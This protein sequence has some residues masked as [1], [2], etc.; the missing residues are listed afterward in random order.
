MG[1]R[2]IPAV[3]V[4]G[5]KYSSVGLLGLPL[6]LEYDETTGGF[7]LV[8][9][10]ENTLEVT[11]TG[12]SVTVGSVSISGPVVQANNVLGAQYAE[13]S[14]HVS[15]ETG[16][17]VL[18]VRQDSPLALAGAGD[19]T[20]F[21]TDALGRLHTFT[22][23]SFVTLSS[24]LQIGAVEI[25]DS[26]TDD[27]V[28]VTADG[29]LWT[30]TLITGSVDTEL[31]AAST[32]ADFIANPLSPAVQ[33]FPY[34]Y[35]QSND[36]WIRARTV[37]DADALVV[38]SITGSF[39]ST[40]FN[41]FWSNDTLGWHRA[42][43]DLQDRLM[44][45]AVVSGTITTLAGSL[46]AL[47]QRADVA[48]AS[49]VRTLNSDV[50]APGV[51]GVS[52]A[53]H[54][55]SFDQ[56]DDLWKRNRSI[57]NVDTR[58]ASELMPTLAV[59]ALLQAFRDDVTNGVY[60]RI[61]GDLQNRLHT[62]AFVT[63]T[64]VVDSAS[65]LALNQRADVAIASPVVSLF[66]D[67]LVSPPT[68]IAA[69]SFLLGYDGSSWDRVGVV[70]VETPN[71]VSI[72]G[73]FINALITAGMNLGFDSSFTGEWKSIGAR[74]P[75]DAMP[76]TQNDIGFSLQS[77][78]YLVGFSVLGSSWNRLRTIGTD[79]DNIAINAT[80]GT[81]QAGAFLYGF[82][83]FAWDRVGI[84]TTR[85]LMTSALVT[86]S[87]TVLPGSSL[88]LNQP[89]DVRIV[90]PVGAGG[91]N[92]DPTATGVIAQSR[93]YGYDSGAGQWGRVERGISGSIG[94]DLFS[95][96]ERTQDE[97]TAYVTGTFP[98]QVTMVSGSLPWKNIIRASITISGTAVGEATVVSAVPGQRIHILELML[99]TDAATQI[100]WKDGSGGSFL[101]G[102][103]ALPNAGDG[104]FLQSPENPDH[105]HFRTS[106]NTALILLR[107]ANTLL[108]GHIHYFL[109]P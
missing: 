68:G 50:L 33:T 27:R 83:G 15:G 43:R 62:R 59:G 30:S 78:S 80:E 5:E 20:P 57:S 69:A 60:E 71:P 29:R 74:F 92:I 94:V 52:T 55:M 51:T 99:L 28:R 79:R 66:S 6:V 87:V 14:L 64:V 84:D 37:R 21:Q 70:S 3:P 24:D 31:P 41:R 44:V 54:G 48:I 9:D 18:A 45:A 107:T 108:G 61:H 13:D 81:L 10:V 75:T 42:L 19:Y 63:G 46:T 34:L 56:A 102:P 97:V 36:L 67:N 38:R 104:Y 73:T 7:K 103:H 8:I 95:Q 23:G 32:P 93:L 100:T 1:H 11:F 96:L 39:A 88:F 47:S 22:S 58:L 89:A 17:F 98:L 35:D 4:D 16:T 12:V 49:P 40:S 26:A 2:G 91:A 85:R 72:T 90:S 76:S 53:A 109:E 86:G 101:S 25:K 77:L 65:T 105:Y 106:A 82:D